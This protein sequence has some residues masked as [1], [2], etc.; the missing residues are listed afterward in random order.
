MMPSQDLLVGQPQRLFG[1]AP[2][3]GPSTR[4]LVLGSFP[5]AASLARQQY[6]AQAQ[7]H[8]WK[9]LQALGPAQP[10]PEVMPK[11]R[12]PS[13]NSDVPSTNPMVAA[14]I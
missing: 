12:K 11:V 9:I 4:L 1:L 14:M 8:F 13:R 2:V 5:G 10:L 7:N 3:A 6:Y